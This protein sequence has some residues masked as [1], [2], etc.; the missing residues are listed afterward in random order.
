VE[1]I[2]PFEVEPVAGILSRLDPPARLVDAR[3][4]GVASAAQGRYSVGPRGGKRVQLGIVIASV[5]EGRAGAPITDWFEAIAHRHGAF[6]AT[7]LDL[8]Q[9]DLPM[10]HEAAHPRLGKYES[11]TTRAWSALV[12]RMDAFVFVTPEYNYGTPPALVNAVD[13]LFAE[14]AYKAVGFVSYG[15][16]AGGARSV[17]MTKQIVTTLKMVP[18]VEAVAIAFFSQWMDATTGRFKGNESLERNAI[19]MLDELA[20]WTGALRSLR[21][22]QAP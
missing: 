17:Q 5:R 9:V 19:S 13:H 7:R 16:T 11:E 22:Q 3:R 6:E 14:W 1:H 2:H 8:K 4:K 18:L 12:A 21:T 20:R 15:G 10:L